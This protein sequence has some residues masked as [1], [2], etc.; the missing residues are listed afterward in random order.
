[1]RVVNDVNNRCEWWAWTNIATRDTKQIMQRTDIADA[2]SN[3]L[4]KDGKTSAPVASRSIGARNKSNPSPEC[5]VILIFAFRKRSIYSN[6][7]RGKGD[8][9]FRVRY[10][11]I[12]INAKRTSLVGR[13][14]QG[15]VRVAI[16]RDQNEYSS[17]TSR[18]GWYL[19]WSQSIL[20]AFLDW[21]ILCE[22]HLERH[23]HKFFEQCVIITFASLRVD[24]Q[25]RSKC[26][27]KI[28]AKRHILALLSGRMIPKRHAVAVTMV[29]V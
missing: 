1:M 10:L 13:M 11:C 14:W 28:S 16:C 29:Q 4:R 17:S 27:G 3:E 8:S 18:L 12:M 9:F 5:D 2:W 26:R 20:C 23:A 21:H 22:F 7:K 24:L 15:A 25:E 19:F 6:W